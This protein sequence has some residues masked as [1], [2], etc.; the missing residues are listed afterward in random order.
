MRKICLIAV[1]LF[2]TTAAH[3]EV[4]RGLIMTS[5]EA[6]PAPQPPAAVVQPAPVP[7]P[8]PATTIFQTTNPQ[9]QMVVKQL[10]AHGLIKAP[11]APQVAQATS[12]NIVTLPAPNQQ[13][14][15][16]PAQVQQTVP[17][18][19]VQVQPVQ[20]PVVQ[21]QVAPQAT[22]PVSQPQVAQP[23]VA[24]PQV[25]QPQ[26]A[27]APAT[28]HTTA[29]KRVVHTSTRHE[30]DEAKARRIAARYGIHW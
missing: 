26:V 30:T 15:V 7:A 12:A 22:A 9:A 1:A 6:A 16:Q 29:S 5:A 27:Q 21:N 8:A 17:T 4:S 2:A 28:S 18:Q 23:Q 25:A 11:P 19:P 14:Q 3:A 10:E 13:G 24:Q 20:T